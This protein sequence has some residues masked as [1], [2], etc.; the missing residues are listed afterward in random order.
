M[1]FL[2]GVNWNTLE[3]INRFDLKICISYFIAKFEDLFPISNKGVKA[4]I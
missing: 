1:F 4:N 2:D 3:K